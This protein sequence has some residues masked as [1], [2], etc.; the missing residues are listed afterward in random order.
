MRVR[1]A[2]ELPPPLQRRLRRARRLEWA[3]LGFMASIVAVIYLTMGGSQAMKAAWIED[4][5]SFVAPAAFLVS[6]R[7]AARDPDE[8]HPYGFH[9][10]VSIAFLAGAVALTLF[11][12]YILLDSVMG[13]ARREHPTIGLSVVAG[14]PVWGGWTMI[15]ALA[16]SA[17][18]PLVLGRMKLPLA[19]ELH[20]KTLKAD[21]DMNK[22]DWLTAGAGIAGILGVGAGLWW[23]DAVA[24]G[25]ISLD[26]LKDGLQNLRRVVL[27]LMDRTPTTV[28]GETSDVPDRVRS[29]V[30]GLAWVRDVE[31]RMREEGH[32]LTGELFVATRDG[33]AT[34]ARIAHAV[35][36]AR[37]VDWRVHD[38]TCT[39]VEGGR[40]RAPGASPGSA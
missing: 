34:P 31:V 36:V 21:A 2:V 23:A 13:L 7:V 22:A 9:R 10:A 12:G 39:I 35:A 24:A 3:T 18:P 25:I 15:A 6:T 29:A 14:R 1:D 33:A 5:L 26:I 40:P 20:D 28:D 19:H 11:G 16:Y 4:L 37:A 30:L 8:E 32:V 27:D 17:V 38:V